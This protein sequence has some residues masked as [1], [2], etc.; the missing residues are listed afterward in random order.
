MRWIW[1]T[2]I[3]GWLML[4]FVASA[5]LIGDADMP[6]SRRAAQLALVWLVPVLGAVVCL[7]FRATDMLGDRQSIDRTAFVNNADAT[8]EQAPGSSG[9]SFD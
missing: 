1:I 3:A 5:K 9:S 4:N 6:R 7:V 2:L 8:G